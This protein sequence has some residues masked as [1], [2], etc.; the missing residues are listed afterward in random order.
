MQY[1]VNNKRLE[2]TLDP[3]KH[4]L[5]CSMKGFWEYDTENAELE[6]AIFQQLSL[7]RNIHTIVLDTSAMKIM[8]PR[9]AEHFLPILTKYLQEAQIAALAHVGA[10]NNVVLRMQFRRVIQYVQNANKIRHETFQQQHE[11]ELWLDTVLS[12]IL[13]LPPLSLSGKVKKKFR[14][15]MTEIS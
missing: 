2:I 1:I 9:M 3:R 4:R 10:P 7:R 12:E 11:A 8:H 5:Y 15:D 6:A 14:S 13:Q